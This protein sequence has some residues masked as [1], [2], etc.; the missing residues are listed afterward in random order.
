MAWS[1]SSSSNKGLVSNLEN[2]RIFQN[3]RVREAMLGVD[4][5]HYCPRNPYQDSPQLIG[6]NVTISAPHMHAMCL[7]ALADHLKP[8]SKALDVGSG[9]GYLTACMAI[10]VGFSG[11]A[12]GVEHVPQL[13][14]QSIS[15]IKADGKEYL[16][17]SKSLIMIEGDGRKGIA[18][19]G[20]YDAIHVGAAAPTIPQSLIDQL[21]PG[22]RLII[23]VGNIMQELLQVDKSLDGNIK[24][25]SITSVR[26]VPLTDL[27]DQVGN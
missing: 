20:P 5:K 17:D 3:S 13:V 2:A 10:M 8:G 16:L 24:Q 23:P 1:C 14:Q 25:K 12:V 6:Y 27:K 11:K 7:D 9:T 19:H 21:K 18:E 22:G 26:Y 4:R 15:N